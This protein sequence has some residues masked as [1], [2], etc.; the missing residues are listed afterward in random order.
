MSLVNFA[1]L[2]EDYLN[3]GR[4]GYIEGRRT[5]LHLQSA[6]RTIQRLAICFAFGLIA[7]LANQEHM[8]A[9]NE[10]AILTAKKIA[11]MLDDGELPFGLYI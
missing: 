1:T 5:G 3:R 4:K 7:G 10:T 6:H 2:V 9:R 11:R 8:D